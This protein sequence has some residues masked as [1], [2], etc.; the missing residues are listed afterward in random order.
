MFDGRLQL[1][2]VLGAAF[3]E[4]GLRLAVALLALFGSGVDGLSSAF[5]L[6][7]TD[8]VLGESFMVRLGGGGAGRAGAPVTAQL[9][10]GGGGGRLQGL[11]VVGVVVR[12]MVLMVLM[13]DE[14]DGGHC[15]AHSG[16]AGR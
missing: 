2:D 13:I 5:A 15:P 1:L 8:V 7:L 11:R 12:V 6:L 14:Q 3:A 4:G 16:D 9:Q 10:L